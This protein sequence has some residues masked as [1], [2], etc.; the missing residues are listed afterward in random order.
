MTYPNQFSVVLAMIILLSAGNTSAG[1]KIDPML[2]LFVQRTAGQVAPSRGLLKSQ[3]AT[4]EPL[5]Q[6]ILRFQGDLSGVESLGGQVQSVIGD[7]A[8]VDIPLNSL[9]AVSQLPNIVYVE[10]AKRVKHR[11]DVSVP[12][13]GASAM[14]SGTAPNLIGYTGRSVVI[15]IIDT[16]IDLNHADFKDAAGKTRILSLWDQTTN[17]VCSQAMIDTGGCAEADTSGHGTHVAGI[18]AGNGA[19]TGNGLAAYRYVG[20]AP[21]ADLVIV[22]TQATTSS[23][24]DGISYVQQQAAARGEPSVI[25]ISLGGHMD[26]HDGTSAYERGLDNAS[27]TGKVIVCAA[28]NEATANIHASGTVVQNVSTTVGFT[29]PAGDTAEALDIW[30]P[31]ADQMGISLSI[32]SCS[33]TVVNPVNLSYSLQTACGL[34]QIVSADVNANN[35]DR[36]ILVILQNGNS[37]LAPGMWNLTL[38]GNSIGANGRF[39]A[40][41]DDSNNA[42]FNDHTDPTI[43]LDDCATAAKPIAVAAYDTKTSFTSQSGSFFY[44]G[45]TQ[46]NIASFSS[47]GPRRQCSTCST[48]P[49]KPEIAAPG[50]GIVSAYSANTAAITGVNFRDYLDLDGVHIISQGTS[51]AAPHVA[52]AAALLLQAVPTYT[53]D[54]IKNLLTGNAVADSFT[55]TVPNNTYTWGYG[56]LAVQAAYAAI[57]N[58]LPAPPAGVAATWTDTSATLTWFANNTVPNVNGYNVYRSTSSGSGYSKIASLGPLVLTY[59]DTGLTAGTYYYYVLRALNTVGN[60]SLNS[61][62]V[63]NAP[64]PVPPAA[65][66]SGGDGGGCFI[67]TAVYGSAL[68]DEVMVLKNFR[69][70]HLLTNTVGRA[71]V[72]FY[73]RHSPPIANYLRVHET[74]RIITRMGLWPVVYTIK[75]PQSA[76]DLLLFSGFAVLGLRQ[77]RKT[78]RTTNIRSDL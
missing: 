55:G 64:P 57:P 66:G 22:K 30:Y 51:M 46:G 21:D 34:V 4:A 65:G 43:T 44:P 13:T 18:A 78:N 11:L 33:T 2:V 17:T 31:G 7:V 75:Y 74:P 61:K 16:G 19:A 62:E 71:F 1:T 26:P 35:G 28:G 38:H 56:K 42:I 29:I 70:R 60:E 58:P 40:W 45:E 3:I 37:A 68:A 52:G 10:A 15:G 73:Y 12:A 54:Q 5:V 14:R 41:I 50:L 9:D 27:G 36:E 72:S 6:T 32:G 8:T 24:L 47:H 63:T 23:I 67:A 48:S 77:R 59:Q 25:N 69:D 76:V 49:Q 39:D 20:M 53:S